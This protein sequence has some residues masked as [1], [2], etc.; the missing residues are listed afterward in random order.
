M[1]GAGQ[2]KKKQKTT[3]INTNPPK[4]DDDF[5]CPI[6][7]EII[8]EAFMTKLSKLIEKHLAGTRNMIGSSSPAATKSLRGTLAPTAES[9]W[10]VNDINNILS[11]LL[12]RKRQLETTQK[13]IEL[14]L[15]SEFLKKAKQV[16]E[17]ELTRVTRELEII[18][19]DL[20]VVSTQ[21]S[22]T[23]F[24]RPDALSAMPMSS[25]GSI[26]SNGEVAQV[27]DGSGDAI[28]ADADGRTR[29][30]RRHSDIDDNEDESE[31]ASVASYPTDTTPNRIGIDLESS[32]S[33]L[34]LAKKQKERVFRHFDELVHTY[35]DSR[36]ANLPTSVNK[37]S[38]DLTPLSRFSTDLYN[39]SRPSRLTV[40]A[41]IYYADNFHN[42][43]SAIV[44]SIDYDRDDEFFATAGVLK[45]IKIFEFASIVSDYRD[46]VSSRDHV[47]DQTDE[48][49]RSRA[50][51]ITSASNNSSP[52]SSSH[53]ATSPRA[54]GLLGS[55]TVDDGVSRLRRVLS[56][57]APRNPG[58]GGNDDQDDIAGGASSTAAAEDDDQQ[59]AAAIET[60]NS[61]AVDDEEEDDDDDDGASGSSRRPARP[62]QPA[63]FAVED[64][65]DDDVDLDR[66]DGLDNVP[67]YPVREV[68]CRSKISC[69]SWNSY[70]KAQ[71]ASSD[72]EGL[73]SLWDV[74]N[75][76][77]LTSYDEHEKRT[78]SCDFS[79][80][81][82][83]R[84]ASGGDDSRIKIW[85]TNQARSV[86]TIDSKANICAVKF[87]PEVGHQLAFGSAD[88]NIH[89][90]DLR[91][92][93]QAL[94]VF[95]GHRKAVSYVKFPHRDTMLTASTD[96]TLR[97]WSLSQVGISSQPSM[98]PPSYLSNT[99]RH[100]GTSAA[101]APPP[102]S[103][104]VPPM[105]SS[106]SNSM[107]PT[108]I[109]N[110]PSMSNLKHIPGIPAGLDP[111]PPGCI[112]AFV[113]HTNEKN[114]VG[115]SVNSDSQFVA[116]G[117]ETNSVFVYWLHVGSPVVVY[118][119]GNGVD[120]VTG[121][122]LADEDPAQFVSSVAYRR[123]HPNVL[124]AANSQGRVK[125][126]EMV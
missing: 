49:R 117:S 111:L 64:E 25:G 103:L 46:T 60:D 11:S 24:R 61:S 112:R 115:L 33:T 26:G 77:L 4:L 73:V 41:K 5:Q 121:E 78:W 12:D 104:L 85:S 87:N 54:R 101:S 20:D 118:K 70:I 67:R 7:R 44:S 10:S 126:L 72:Y 99:T 13:E 29:R 92:T 102:S 69:L 109:L 59:Q 14:E 58:G 23:S 55:T 40:L 42:P 17:D 83:T 19:T 8:T 15:V 22:S 89:Y 50:G 96:C 80:V 97:L 28:V 63:A 43:G 57:I 6:C 107:G 36:M 93:A 34:K 71:L 116:C 90:Y 74:Q 47:N 56:R 79:R 3:S 31:T 32:T 75:G 18:Q 76:S 106:N 81:D 68:A 86:M 48:R 16:K 35:F 30:K 88:H 82:P 98:G 124:I 53:T 37:K 65:D 119:F 9:H 122:E 1:S 108:G 27:P 95:K 45:R 120:P 39:F 100:P 94:Y 62:S 38:K 21:Y 51:F 105:T 2:A 110:D 113:G 66:N 123:T 114:F 91:N 125:V 52:S 84:L